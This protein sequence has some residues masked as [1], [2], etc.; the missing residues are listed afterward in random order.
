M[1]KCAKEPS[2]THDKNMTNRS[3]QNRCQ[4]RRESLKNHDKI[5]PWFLSCCHVC[6]RRLCF[7]N[8][9]RS[10][11]DQRHGT[12]YAGGEWPRSSFSPARKWDE[13]T[14][15]CKGGTL[16][17]QSPR[18]SKVQ[19]FGNQNF[20]RFCQAETAL[21]QSEMP[22]NIVF[23]ITAFKVRFSD[24]LSANLKGAEKKRTLQKHPFGQTFLRTM[25]SP[26]LWRALNLGALH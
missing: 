9:R 22:L 17:E 1:T 18:F 12:K 13:W 3:W 26:L 11:P 10:C 19:C 2:C 5:L 21:S 25:L 14:W 20:D 23:W 15:G 8:Y 7:K 4:F 24:V 16:W 6:V